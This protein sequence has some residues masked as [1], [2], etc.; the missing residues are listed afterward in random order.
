[1]NGVSGTR[2]NRGLPATVVLRMKGDQPVEA[3]KSG[4]AAGDE[5]LLASVTHP[6]R[7]G[8]ARPIGALMP[9]V[10]ARYGLADAING[11]TPVESVT[12]DVL[13]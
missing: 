6:P 3:R 12:V 5:V 8:E 10:L 4:N 9:E 13:A 11:S 2:S 1:M 7:I